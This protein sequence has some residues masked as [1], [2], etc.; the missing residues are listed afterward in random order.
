MPLSWPHLW[1]KNTSPAAGSK[2]CRLAQRRQG[3]AQLSIETLEDRCLLS[4][5][6]G[7]TALGLND[8]ALIYDSMA[9][10]H[11]IR[12]P[13]LSPDPALNAQLHARAWGYLTGNLGGLVGNIVSTI[14]GAD[15]KTVGLAIKTGGDLFRLGSFLLTNGLQ[16]G[17]GPAAKALHDV[18]EARSLIVQA[19][20]DFDNY[21][22]T[23]GNKK[24]AQAEPF[25]KEAVQLQ[26]YGNSPYAHQWPPISL[27]LRS[28]HRTPPRPRLPC[29][30]RAV[31]AEAEEVEEAVVEEAEAE[32][33]VVEAEEA[34]EVLARSCRRSSNSWLKSRR[35]SS[36]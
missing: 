7:N 4:P 36:R 10:I 25:V 2:T 17:D 30:C 1:K 22:V 21:Q 20:E 32:A 26:P 8:A 34:A 16:V 23:D 11:D 28:R 14:P 35:R 12:E 33:A 9:Q 19:R 13:N 24:L 15:T 18:I 6:L 5:G 27:A 3:R 31:V 29:N